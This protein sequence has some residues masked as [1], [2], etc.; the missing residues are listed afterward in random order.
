MSVGPERYVNDEGQYPYFPSDL[1]LFELRSVHAVEVDW[2]ASD[3]AILAAFVRWRDANRP[4]HD[5]ILESRG[6]GGARELLKFLAA[7]RLMGHFGNNWIASVEWVDEHAP[8]ED[9]GKKSDGVPRYKDDSAWRKA[10][11]KATRLIRAG[12]GPTPARMLEGKLRASSLTAMQ[13]ARLAISIKQAK[14]GERDKATAQ[15]AESL[16]ERAIRAA[17]PSAESGG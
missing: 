15:E 4:T 9:N 2:T 3:E 13:R 11:A 1:G 12:V 10:A 5:V 8:K 16:L 17:L 14:R 6:R 7:H